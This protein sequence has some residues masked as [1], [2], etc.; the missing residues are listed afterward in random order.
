MNFTSRTPYEISQ[1]IA[2]VAVSNWYRGYRR[3]K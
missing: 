3:T 2:E 1:R